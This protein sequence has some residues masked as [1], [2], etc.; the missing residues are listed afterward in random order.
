MNAIFVLG[1][2]LLFVL[3]IVFGT[4]LTRKEDELGFLCECKSGK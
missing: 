3:Y 2:V 1:F 4:K